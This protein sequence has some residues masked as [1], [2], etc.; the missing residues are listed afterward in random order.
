MEQQTVEGGPEREQATRLSALLECEAELARL[1]A[2]A[3]DIARR[4]VEEARGEAARAESDLAASLDAEGERAR[5]RIQ[6]SSQAT[7]QDVLSG[8][9]ARVVRY[10][11]VSDAEVLRLA[12]SALRRLIAE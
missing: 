6:S 5:H 7:V 9:R 1:M 3:R 10:E 12:Q 11:N 8:A 4:R 2:E